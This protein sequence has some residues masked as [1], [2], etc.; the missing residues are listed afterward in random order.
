MCL[1]YESH[2]IC[3]ARAEDFHVN[4]GDFVDVILLYLPWLLYL[5]CLKF[6]RL[7][8]LPYRKHNLSELQS[9]VTGR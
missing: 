8:S 3:E 1:K 9:S 5:D 7:Q 4:D 6:L 2:Y